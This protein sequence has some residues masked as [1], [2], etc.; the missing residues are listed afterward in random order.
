MPLCQPPRAS[1]NQGHRALHKDKARNTHGVG[2]TETQRHHTRPGGQRS[3]RN[4]ETHR[5]RDAEKPDPTGPQLVTLHG[6]LETCQ[7]P[8]PLT[9]G[10][11]LGVERLEFKG[12]E[13]RLSL[14]A[15]RLHKASV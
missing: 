3:P 8:T 1:G 13:L 2:E 11:D 15:N 6:S 4:R 9:S 10:V 5:D 14:T 12:K 7:G